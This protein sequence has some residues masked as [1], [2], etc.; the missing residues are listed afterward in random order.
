MLNSQHLFL[1]G[2]LIG[3]STILY[4]HNVRT[5]SNIKQYVRFQYQNQIAYGLLENETV[6]ELKGLIFDQT[7]KTG[8]SYPLQKVKLLIPCEPTKVLAVG[9]NYASHVGDRPKP[10]NPELFF[11]SPSI[12]FQLV[13][14]FCKRYCKELF[15]TDLG[16]SQKIYGSR[17]V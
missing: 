16:I 13:H 12:I 10:K 2:L 1:I 3:L 5:Q 15:Q 9:L 8:N 11:K 14:C 7:T 4:H 17:V 6:Y